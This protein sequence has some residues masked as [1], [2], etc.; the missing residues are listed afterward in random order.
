MV[1]VE[2][3]GFW[4]CYGPPILLAIYTLIALFI[5]WM[6]WNFFTKIH[7]LSNAS[8]QSI[9]KLTVRSTGNNIEYNSEDHWIRYKDLTVYFGNRFM[10]RLLIAANN[11]YSILMRG[12]HGYETV[13]YDIN[14]TTFITQPSVKHAP[15]LATKRA[16]DKSMSA[17][18]ESEETPRSGLYLRAA[19]RTPV[20]AYAVRL[21][22]YYV[23]L[24]A[25]NNSR[26]LSR[27]LEAERRRKDDAQESGNPTFDSEHGC[28]RLST[29]HQ[30]VSREFTKTKKSNFIG[31]R[32]SQ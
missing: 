15:H 8:G 13:F 4:S 30:I 5:L 29:D 19:S 27:A 32:V 9:H 6:I 26:A 3:D 17:I 14:N 11:V 10:R 31:V 20:S 18:A 28:I 25:R 7:L 12:M 24:D 1:N 2:R 16:F 21:G 22:I 23:F